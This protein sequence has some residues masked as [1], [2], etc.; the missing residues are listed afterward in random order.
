MINDQI[1]IKNKKKPQIQS[2]YK[3]VSDQIDFQFYMVIIN[4]SE[5]GS[6][7]QKKVDSQ[8]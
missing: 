2:H 7:T 1:K 6:R 3:V 8:T 4:F 5:F